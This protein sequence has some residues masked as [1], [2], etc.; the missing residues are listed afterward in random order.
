MTDQR[1]NEI[2]MAMKNMA[3]GDV[4]DIAEVGISVSKNQYGTLTVTGRRNK[5]CGYPYL[6]LDIIDEIV[7]E[8]NLSQVQ[9]L[10]KQFFEENNARIE[11]GIILHRVDHLRLGGDSIR[12]G[13]DG[14]WSEWV[15][16]SR[17]EADAWCQAHGATFR[18][19]FP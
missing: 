4:I 11:R 9:K 19:L 16:M 14:S 15:P 18:E 2:A 10:R 12:D 6:V 7:R 8:D 1:M 5:V 13:V 3:S 17:E